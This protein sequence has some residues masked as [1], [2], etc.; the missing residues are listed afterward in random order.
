MGVEVT[1][2]KSG[3]R[4]STSAHA[5]GALLGSTRLFNKYYFMYSVPWRSAM[6]YIQS[7]GVCA[8]MCV[9]VHTCMCV[10]V[11]TCMCVH[12]HLSLL[13]FN[14]KGRTMR[15]TVTYYAMLLVQF[16]FIQ[17]SKFDWWH[18]RP[19]SRDCDIINCRCCDSW[20][21]C[22][23]TAWAPSTARETFHQHFAHHYLSKAWI[24]N[25][26]ESSPLTTHHSLE[27]VLVDSWLITQLPHVVWSNVR[28]E[29]LD[30]GL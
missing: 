14:L 15:L 4:K 2:V 10:H 1:A 12:V 30:T 24:C 3:C 7:T 5:C 17:S 11:H 16:Y 23:R 28:M 18:T 27:F 20:L 19:Q 13:G 25:K 26:K 9:H 21:L 6:F 8:Y 22:G 29:M